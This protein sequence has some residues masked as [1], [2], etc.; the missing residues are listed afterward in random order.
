MLSQ[1][2]CLA[3]RR[4]CSTKSRRLISIGRVEYP[5]FTFLT[6]GISRIDCYSTEQ[7][8]KATKLTLK[9]GQPLIKIAIE[10]YSRI[11]KIIMNMAQ[12]IYHLINRFSAGGAS[13]IIQNIVENDTENR[14]TICC[15][16]GVVEVDPDN[17]DCEFISLNERHKFDP[18]ALLRLVKLFMNKD[19]DILHLHLPYSQTVGRLAMKITDINGVI[20]TQHNTPESHHPVTRYLEFMTRR[21]DDE[22]VAVSNGI[23]NFNLN[24]VNSLIIGDNIKW[25][26]IHNSID[27]PKFNQQ[28]NKSD[29]SYANI[30]TRDNPILLNVAHYIEQ[31]SHSDLITAMNSI[32]DEYPDA[33]LFCVGRG[34][35]KNEIKNEVSQQG[36]EDYITVTGFVTQEELYR[37]YSIADLFVLSSIREGLSIA[38]IEAMAA[39]LPVVATDIPGTNEIVKHNMTGKLVDKESPEQLANAVCDIKKDNLENEYGKR[40]YHRVISEYSVE[41][42]VCEY[43]KLYMNVSSST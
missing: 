12:N 34:P 17:I 1:R 33:H 21:F 11:N 36:L 5:V 8:R 32:I 25:N 15:M 24:L 22:T 29:T 27:V 41:Q 31:K 28:I 6:R 26:T 13:T 4:H 23:R 19:I 42:S 7:S 18:L 14:H 10:S 3:S 38:L 20:S 39:E 9:N 16:E 35:L 2:A 43:K 30:H 37:Y 40:G